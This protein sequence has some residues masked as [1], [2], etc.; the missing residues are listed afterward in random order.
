M[1][2]PSFMK[3][4]SVLEDAGMITTRKEGRVRS[5]MLKPK[6]LNRA[7]RWFGEQR[8]AWASRYDKLDALLTKL[9]GEK[10]EP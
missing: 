6:S 1:A 7:E 4:I 2:L 3:H 5:C 10:N 8:E 9:S